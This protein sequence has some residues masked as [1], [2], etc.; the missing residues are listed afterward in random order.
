LASAREKGKRLEGRPFKLA[1]E[2]SFGG[3]GVKRTIFRKNF[4]SAVVA[5]KESGKGGKKKK[6]GGRQGTALVGT[7]RRVTYLSQRFHSIPLV[8]S[9]GG[10]P[11]ADGEMPEKKQ[12]PC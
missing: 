7:P 1:M 2:E 5:E 4:G 11:A 6:R 10:I 9:K 8:L 12:H 3:G